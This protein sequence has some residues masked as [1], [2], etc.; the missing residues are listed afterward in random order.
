MSRRKRPPR[1]GQ[2]T[3]YQ[4]GNKWAFAFDGPP[5]PLTG[6]RQ[7]IRKSGFASEDAAWAGMQD[8]RAALATETYV[9]PSRA[10]VSDFF[11]AWFPYVRTTTEPTTAANYEVLARAYVLPL[12]GRRPIQ[13]IGPS[14]VA[15]LY[16]HLL[17]EG[18]RRRD[19]NS[20]M[21]RVWQDARAAKREVRPRKSRTRWASRTRP[22]GRR[23]SAT[24][25]G[26]FPAR[27]TLACHRRPSKRCTSC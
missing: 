4:R 19:T 14:V 8:A 1:R 5:H 20:D 10:K 6:E 12:I 22:P 17:A 11:E 16:S 21:Y 15:A 7:K 13:E 24:R 23:Y 2:G 27:P 3:V 9:K 26:D 25:P 18:R